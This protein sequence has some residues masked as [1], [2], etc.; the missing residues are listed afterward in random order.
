ML[1]DDRAGDVSRQRGVRRLVFAA[2][3]GMGQDRRARLQIGPC[4]QGVAKIAEHQ[5]V[6]G[7]Y[8]VGQGVKVLVESID[9]SVGEDLT[10]VEQVMRDLRAHDCNML[11]LG[12]YLQ[13]SVH[14]LPI[15][16]YLDP[17]EFEHLGELGYRLGFSH[18]ASGP[19]VR[20]S[21]HADQ[22][23][24]SALKTD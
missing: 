21:Y 16:R 7:A 19:M 13:P 14:H 15:E 8:D 2:D 22:Q 5:V 4:R 9:V 24:K 10:E 11:T 6:V 17:D 20:S 23:A 12:Q 18:V 1:V 3:I